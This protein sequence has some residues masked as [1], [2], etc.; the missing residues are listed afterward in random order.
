M[1]D[2]RLQTAIQ[3]VDGY[4]S[5]HPAAEYLKLLAPKHMLSSVDDDMH[6]NEGYCEVVHQGIDAVNSV[7]QDNDLEDINVLRNSFCASN[8]D[9]KYKEE[10]L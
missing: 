2:F 1:N 5:L 10:F 8:N 6:R 9:L 7:D 3:L 4:L